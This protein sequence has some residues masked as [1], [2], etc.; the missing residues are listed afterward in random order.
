MCPIHPLHPE[1]PAELLSKNG[2][3]NTSV[4]N[5][6]SAGRCFHTYFLIKGLIYSGDDD[7]IGN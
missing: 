3:D 6:F 5:S 4:E 2:H 7:K 1:S